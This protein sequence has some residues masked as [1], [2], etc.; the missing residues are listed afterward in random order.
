MFTSYLLTEA[1]HFLHI[2]YRGNVRILSLH[3]RVVVC[4]WQTANGDGLLES[5]SKDFDEMSKPGSRSG[6]VDS[7]RYSHYE[8]YSEIQQHLR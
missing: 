6:F 7:S 4:S 3:H 8:N 5:S 1:S 2:T